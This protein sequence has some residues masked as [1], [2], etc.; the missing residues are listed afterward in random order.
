MT[1]DEG[2]IEA[3][4]ALTVLEYIE[5]LQLLWNQILKNL[6]AEEEKQF[7]GKSVDELVSQIIRDNSERL[8]KFITMSSRN[9]TQK[10]LNSEEEQ[11]LLQFSRLIKYLLHMILYA[12]GVQMKVLQQVD[13][14]QFELSSDEYLS[15]ECPQ[16][17]PQ[18][19]QY[20]HSD[21]L[22]IPLMHITCL[23]YPS[24][25]VKNNSSKNSPQTFIYADARLIVL[26]FQYHLYTSIKT[27]KDYEFVISYIKPRSI[28][29]LWDMLTAEYDFE[30]HLIINLLMIFL[31][32]ALKI[33]DSGAN[34][35][36]QV[37]AN[38]P[39]NQMSFA[40][41]SNSIF[42]A[43][44]YETF[45]HA[46]W[47]V[48]F[49]GLDHGFGLLSKMSESLIKKYD[50]YLWL[51]GP[52]VT[53]L[54]SCV[55]DEEEHV[56]LKSV[57][58]LRSLDPS[59][60]DILVAIWQQYLLILDD[61]EQKIKV[62]QVMVY[63]NGVFPA[64]HLL[65]WSAV[66][67]LLE[68]KPSKV[69]SNRQ[70]ANE[71]GQLLDAKK[72]SA[73]NRVVHDLHM[74]NFKLAAFNM[75]MK[76]IA[77]GQS[78]SREYMARVQV[79]AAQHLGFLDASYSMK[80][81]K[82]IL[83]HFGPAT[84]NVKNPSHQEALLIICR[85]C[86]VMFDRFNVD[87]S[88][89]GMGIASAITMKSAISSNFGNGG[90]QQNQAGGVNGD[91][92]NQ[93][94]TRSLANS[95]FERLLSR[96][97]RIKQQSR[98]MMEMMSHLNDP[99]ELIF[100]FD[101]I[102]HTVNGADVVCQLDPTLLKCWLD[103][104]FIFIYKFDVESQELLP[105]VVFVMKTLLAAILSGSVSDE[106]ARIAIALCHVILRRSVV[107]TTEIMVEELLTFSLIIVRLQSHKS[108]QLVLRAKIF[109]KALFDVF[110]DSGLFILVFTGKLDISSNPFYK[111]IAASCQIL[112]N[113]LFGALFQV[114]TS[115]YSSREN[116]AR[117]FPFYEL[118]IRDVAQR[119]W[120]YKSFTK[121]EFN[122]IIKNMTLFIVQTRPPLRG[123]SVWGEL[124][125]FLINLTVKPLSWKREQWNVDCILDLCLVLCNQYSKGF[126]MIANA[127]KILLVHVIDKCQ[128]E[129]D[130]LNALLQ[131]C[132]VSQLKQ[133]NSRAENVNIAVYNL[134]KSK[135]LSE[136]SS[137]QKSNQ[138][139]IYSFLLQDFESHLKRSNL[140]Y[141]EVANLN[142]NVVFGTNLATQSALITRKLIVTVQSVASED[143][144]EYHELS[145]FLANLCVLMWK[146]FDNAIQPM[147][148]SKKLQELD[149]GQF[150]RLSAPLLLGACRYFDCN[151]S[152]A[153]L[154]N[155]SKYL[156]ALQFILNSIA[157]SMG[158]GGFSLASTKGA[159]IG[160][161]DKTT[162]FAPL[163]T[164]VLSPQT[165]KV[166]NPF[167]KKNVNDKDSN[168][169]DQ[170]DALSVVSS[171]FFIIKCLSLLCSTV[172]Q[173]LRPYGGKEATVLDVKI[174]MMTELVSTAELQVRNY[175]WPSLMQ[176]LNKEHYDSDGREVKIKYNNWQYFLETVNFWRLSYSDIY[177]WHSV[178]LVQFI[179]DHMV[180]LDDSLATQ[181][182]YLIKCSKETA[183]EKPT[184]EQLLSQLV[185]E[186]LGNTDV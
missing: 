126:K 118:P 63:I 150:L 88:D 136:S 52:L 68:W 23:K 81:D 39:A 24:K 134:I 28:L 75:T 162:T 61:V 87:V 71:S 1:L 42:C 56:R 82:N 167:D 93:A 8:Q 139:N 40:D 121:E 114:W 180:F 47:Q 5:Q 179:D 67:Q 33:G 106:V 128:F 2:A 7:D 186:Y 159:N 125:Q 57:S 36:F 86:K 146:D 77:I 107:I 26:K 108:H 141:S 117:K 147:L 165:D 31:T 143:R 170:A 73:L 62:L 149:V 99:P 53:Y 185:A 96:S 15:F 155:W 70:M 175:M 20:I 182:Q 101:L 158:N 78:I 132:H 92:K 16:P 144:K 176:L 163:R 166:F 157:D 131:Q 27:Q 3:G 9:Q 32:F 156:N 145:V 10:P 50:S 79:L 49:V 116:Q 130:A 98:I 54:M 45:E 89:S 6:D 181:A 25:A 58:L 169:T 184:T 30:K 119:I 35:R 104:V 14:V 72:Q 174:S 127:L 41:F 43:C 112:E 37:G 113:D 13:L 137:W 102:C 48:R 59:R 183:T 74:R 123:R 11:F 153:L 64:L 76:M 100:F 91:L 129:V 172:Q 103:C 161:D 109:L 85:S 83:V 97:E 60:L 154:Q 140:L 22:I 111:Q 122:A 94:A 133:E 152:L 95:G 177:R 110:Y 160:S 168:G 135:L 19:H 65:S 17:L 124:S 44:I 18:E 55:L 148:F 142:Q 21:D 84:F 138:K 164:A 171:V 51:F 173:N 38:N 120:L 80:T 105:K 34:N 66:F 29:V 12:L 90:K 46:N 151:F 69:S 178:E 4:G 115:Q